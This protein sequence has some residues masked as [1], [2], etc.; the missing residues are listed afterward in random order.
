MKNKN[1]QKRL[2]LTTETLRSLTGDDVQNVVGGAVP[3]GGGR[4]GGE[5]GFTDS[6]SISWA[7]NNCCNC[8]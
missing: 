5:V 4:P 3:G 2:R 6:I 8:K 1:A 7:G